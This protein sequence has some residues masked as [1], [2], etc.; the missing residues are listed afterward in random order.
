MAELP[1]IE[2]LYQM[3]KE[4]KDI[5]VVTFNVDEN[6]GLVHPFLKQH[7]YKFPVLLAHSSLAP[8]W[9][10]GIPQNWIVDPG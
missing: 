7:Q 6:P 8:C 1:H 4:R 2:K 9:T 5:Q 3:T 10:G